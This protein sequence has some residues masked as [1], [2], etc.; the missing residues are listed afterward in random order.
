MQRK[1]EAQDSFIAWGHPNI[2]SKHKTTLMITTDKHLTK[3]GDCIVAVRAEKGLD[4]LLPELKEIIRNEEAKVV[5]IM[6]TR[7]QRLLVR[8]RGHPG[9][10][11]TSPSDMVIRKSSFICDRTLMIRADIAALDIPPEFVR[12]LEGLDREV[13]ITI[14]AML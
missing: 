13:H 2:T 4:D 3:E 7:G 9:L 1:R 6:E 11:L 12:F 8:G 14:R 10:M 5:F